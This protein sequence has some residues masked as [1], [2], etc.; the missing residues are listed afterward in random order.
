[1]DREV[2]Q[3]VLQGGGER[4]PGQ[5]EVTVT[6]QPARGLVVGLAEERQPEATECEIR[7]VAAK[8]YVRGMMARRNE[9]GDRRCAWKGL[10]L[11]E[12]GRP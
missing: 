1:M 2:S 3:Q 11:L 5:K 9:T 8:A 7:G 6:A 10:L 12:A 4:S